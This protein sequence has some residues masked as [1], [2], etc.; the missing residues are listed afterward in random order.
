MK[1]SYVTIV[2]FVCL[3]KASWQVHGIKQHSFQTDSLIDLIQKTEHNNLE[4]TSRL[5]Q[6]LL[7]IPNNKQAHFYGAYYLAKASYYKNNMPKAL[8][9]L[10]K[11]YKT[12]N[13]KKYNHIKYEID[14]LISD[15]Y[16]R[17]DNFEAGYERLKK[18]SAYG[19][20][21][22]FRVAAYLLSNYSY[23]NSERAIDYIRKNIDYTKG[24]YTKANYFKERL[25]LGLLK[26]QF[27][28]KQHLDF[29]KAYLEN[30]ALCKANG[31]IDLAV[32]N[33]HSLIYTLAHDE[34]SQLHALDI[35]N[36]GIELSKKMKNTF[37]L[38]KLYHTKGHIHN[39]LYGVYFTNRKNL[40]EKV[41]KTELH[42]LQLQHLD[43]SYQSYEQ[44]L[45][46]AH[47]QQNSNRV[48]RLYSG[49]GATKL[50][51]NNIKKEIGVLKEICTLYSCAVDEIGFSNFEAIKILKARINYAINLLGHQPCLDEVNIRVYSMAQNKHL[52][53]TTMSVA[54][55]HFERDFF[56]YTSSL[57][58]KHATLQT[59]RNIL[60]IFIP[61]L[62]LSLTYYYRQ[63]YIMLKQIKEQ[64][65]FI[66]AQ[67]QSLKQAV[68]RL[69][70]ANRGLENFAFTAAHDLK[71]PLRTI[72]SF[73][74]LLK[75]KYY[76]PNSEDNSLFFDYITKGCEDL[77]YFVD[78]LLKFSTIIH[79]QTPAQKIELNN[80]LNNILLKI[81]PVLKKEKICLS[82]DEHLPTIEAHFSL[83][84]QL[85]HNLISNSI[86]FSKPDEVNFIHIG[87]L[88]KE[89]DLIF[90]VKD[91][92]IGIPVE[93]QK[94]VFDLFKKVYANTE[95]NGFGI[96]L[97]TC[98][99]IVHYYEGKLWLDSTYGESTIAYFTLPKAVNSKSPSLIAAS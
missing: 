80:V 36:E 71:S 4:K 40:I 34:A 64:H 50:T 65:V 31:W 39:N 87:Y 18:I 55:T 42:C 70:R 79:K 78:N 83:M 62:L 24:K 41:D 93:K 10:N 86:K 66:Q 82:I 32:E 27:K 19:N 53:N 45:R 77:G 97:A 52:T 47:I 38:T 92:G 96:G 85:W 54:K 3:I 6:Q 58:I 2:L 22:D 9:Q 25:K 74:G 15:Y 28:Q 29:K 99:K 20:D 26:L 81:K 5:A 88:I 35:C 11:L 56:E 84:Y 7:Q 95:Y 14:L 73:T 43:A 49:L 76:D 21:D 17:Q 33:L 89:E 51:R 75:R 90:Y 68:R 63:K 98:K 12:I 46:Y 37:L 91:K 44:G 1:T 23:L 48:S 16:F 59:L 67:N 72:A 13:R 61:L 94:E 57:K 60:L 8:A 69:K 30:V